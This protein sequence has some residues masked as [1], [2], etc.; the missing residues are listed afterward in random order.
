MVFGTTPGMVSD[1]AVVFGV[2]RLNIGAGTDGMMMFVIGGGIGATSAGGAKDF[3]GAGAGVGA[4]SV[5]DGE[6]ADG[7]TPGMLIARGG[8][9]GVD[10]GV[11]VEGNEVVGFGA[12][13]VEESEVVG[14]GA[15]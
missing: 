5:I 9:V 15:V 6:G 12:M 4:K 11:K 8:F 14:V 3:I 10:S 7:V 13:K 1:G 2:L